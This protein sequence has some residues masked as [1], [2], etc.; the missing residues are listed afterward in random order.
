MGTLTLTVFLSSK[1][2][3]MISIFSQI[4]LN[5]FLRSNGFGGSF[6]I[7]ARTTHAPL[8]LK[9]E[10]APVDSNININ[11]D[12]THGYSVVWLPAA[13]EGLYAGHTTHGEAS[14]LWQHVEDPKQ[15]GRKRKLNQESA[16]SGEVKG[17]VSW[18][19]RGRERGSVVVGTTH[20]PV[21]IR[22]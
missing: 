14:M 16:R 2:T 22:F 9:V 8:T 10:K 3:K 20:A 13:Y 17:S 21:S 11:T 15:E 6:H 12:T 5:T 4:G 19:E 7:Q 1:L 18:S